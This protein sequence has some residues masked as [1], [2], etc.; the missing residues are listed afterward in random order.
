MDHDNRQENVQPA[1]PFA[2]APYAPV[3]GAPRPE[4]PRLVLKKR[5]WLSLLAA[6]LLVVYPA[7]AFYIGT[8]FEQ[9]NF[10]GI[11]SAVFF[12]AVLGFGV[13]RASFEKL[14]THKA[15]IFV[16]AAAAAS[17]VSLALWSYLPMRLLNHFAAFILTAIGL[18]ALSGMNRMPLS[19]AGMLGESFVNSFR[20]MFSH[21]GKPFR[22]MPEAVGRKKS[23]VLGVVIGVAVSIPLLAVLI[24]LLSSADI[25]FHD[26]VSGWLRVFEDIN[27]G[28]ILWYGVRIVFFT[29]LLFSV[30]YAL[31]HPKPLRE[32]EHA[33]ARVPAS[34]TMTVLILIAVLY[35]IF[36]SSIFWGLA[37]ANLRDPAFFAENGGYAQYARE[38]FFQLA[39]VAAINFIA[40]GI[41]SYVN[42]RHKGV[43]T[44]AV[45]LSVQTLALLGTAVVRMCCYIGAYGLSFLRLATFAGM[46]VI[47][48]AMALSIVK[49]FRPDYKIFPV[50]GCVTLA[51]WMVFTLCD[52]SRVIAAYNV[53]A[54]LS[55]SL[56]SV[57][58]EYLADLSP[59]VIPELER[60]AEE[61]SDKDAHIARLRI[62]EVK[63]GERGGWWIW[64]FDQLF[65][66]PDTSAARK[67]ESGVYFTAKL[68]LA[69]DVYAVTMSYYMDGE[70]CGSQTV[71]QASERR[72]L[73]RKE[74]LRFELAKPFD[75]P[76]DADL[77]GLSVQFSIQPYLES[78]PM[79]AGERL[80]PSADFGETRAYRLEGGRDT[81]YTAR[82]E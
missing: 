67:F 19:R 75:I 9:N 82:P 57:D 62:E 22:A 3:P 1:A 27:I 79:D 69:E 73:G 47:A 53:S 35:F 58:T 16:L 14:R 52:T 66:G 41:A 25:F 40:V 61:G 37:Y 78:D 18:L 17:A 20:A 46:A 56:G 21:F 23:G 55:G 81:G 8:L 7:L 5:D 44:L 28:R 38:G 42:N 45:I 15:C 64:S 50:L 36:F 12:L 10:P 70:F 33:P 80:Y 26:T 51:L 63:A 77:S 31:R 4:K 39:A 68:D 65:L 71:T 49:A 11:G 48:C 54:Y 6:F 24:A 13:Y 32:R 29:L 2:P 72:L 60:L 34:F 59:S 43:R 74:E 30:F 76:A